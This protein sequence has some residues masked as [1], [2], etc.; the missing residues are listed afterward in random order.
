MTRPPEDPLT[1]VELKFM[2]AVADQAALSIRNAQLFEELRELSTHDELTKLANRRLL[3]TRLAQ[4][5]E[6]ARRFRQPVSVLAV[7]IDHFKLLNDRAGHPVGDQALVAVSSLLVNNVRRV[8]TV[9]RVGGE[10]FIVVLP[11]ADLL[12]AMK[13]ADKLRLAIASRTDLPGGSGQPGERLTISI[14]V[15]EFIETED[16]DGDALLSR[17]DQALYAAKREGRNRAVAYTRLESLR[18]VAA[19]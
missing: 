16:Q 14:G 9:A 13:V 18:P 12:E 15:A 17:A 5:L 8:D 4:E 11:A 10:E 19:G 3:A 6:R 7:D 1:E 2:S